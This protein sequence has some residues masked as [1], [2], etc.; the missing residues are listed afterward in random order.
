MNKIKNICIKI[1]L[2]C[3]IFQNVSNTFVFANSNLKIYSR[4]Y[5]SYER[6]TKTILFGKKINDKVPM[7]STTKIMTAILLLEYGNLE[8]YAVASKKAQA[9]TGQ[10]LNL[11]EGDKISLNDLLYAIMLYS[12]NDGAVVI[13]EHIGGSVEGFCQIM[14]EKA[15]SIGC[16][17]TNFTSPHGLD[18]QNHYSTPYDL[19]LITDYAL[20]IPE[21]KKITS[22]KNYT[23]QINGNNRDIRNTNRLVHENTNI[24][25]TKT[26]YT[27]NALYCL[28]A[29]KTE[30][31]KDII[32][33]VLGSNTSNQR[34]DET[35]NILEYSLNE[36]EIVNMKEYMK[37]HME[38][39]V[40]KGKN[41]IN[42]IIPKNIPI[43]CIRKSD[44]EKI[45][46]N[47]CILDNMDAPIKQGEILGIGDVL[48]NQ[49]RIARVEYVS[50]INIDK[51]NHIDYF[52]NIL[53]NI[54]D[55]LKIN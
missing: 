3:L 15:K 47:Y 35:R 14:N 16:V 39:N 31:D 54:G 24:T 23:I 22:T 20:K 34:F 38:V 42:K 9:T 53:K 1:V 4:S 52:Y 46:I 7:A 55:Y 30:G 8:E 13:A 28:V 21:F 29:N 37:D 6:N 45:D 17:N 40:I 10:Q 27:N 19:A 11:K 32:V 51:M 44:K 48:V 12:A 36:Y 43:I 41:L 49:E 18:N 50:D 26:G 5:I 33:V 2:I 25:G